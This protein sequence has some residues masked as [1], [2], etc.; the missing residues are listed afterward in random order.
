MQRAKSVDEYIKS[1]PGWSTALKKMRKILTST[2]LEETVKWGGPC[3]TVGGKDVVGLSAFTEYVALWFHQGVF[4]SDPD[5][6]LINA[7][8][9][10]TRALRQW[11]FPSEASIKVAKVKAYL[12][13]A[14]ENQKQGKAIKADRSKPVLIPPELKTAL[15]KKAKAKKAFAAFTPGRQREYAEH[16]ASAKRAETK[17]S[18]LAKILPMIA[19]GGGLNDKYRDC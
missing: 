1:H 19:S 2:E 5:K 4:L 18:R 11:R 15:A 10:T 3:Y 14:I 9:G 17:T 13:E 8:E 7:Q 16:I 6:V 12:L